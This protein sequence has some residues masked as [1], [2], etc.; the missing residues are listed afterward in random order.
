M[1]GLYVHYLYSRWLIKGTSTVPLS[2]LIYT[3]I[4]YSVWIL[5]VESTHL[6]VEL[7]FCCGGK[8]GCPLSK[9]Y[10]PWPVLYFTWVTMELSQQGSSTEEHVATHCHSHI[11]GQACCEKC[12]IHTCTYTETPWVD[13]VRCCFSGCVYH[14]VFGHQALSGIPTSLVSAMLMVSYNI[15]CICDWLWM[16]IKIW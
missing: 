13:I 1:T 12:S 6:G 8:R 16:F 7:C 5:V 3:L 2:K 15:T 14:W 4:S 11:N 9:C 10:P